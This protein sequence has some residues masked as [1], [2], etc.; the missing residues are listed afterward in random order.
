MEISTV[1]NCQDIG[2]KC[3]PEKKLSNTKQWIRAETVRVRFDSSHE[4]DTEG[5]EHRGCCIRN[6]HCDSESLRQEVGQVESN[7]RYLRQI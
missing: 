6:A 5:A 3:E 1:Y 7:D 2:F 4:D